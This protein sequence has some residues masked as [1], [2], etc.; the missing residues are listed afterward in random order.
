MIVVFSILPPLL[1][2]LGVLVVPPPPSFH[3]SPPGGISFTHTYVPVHTV[4]SWHWG[5]R[6]GGGGNLKKRAADVVSG[7]I[8]CF[9]AIFKREPLIFFRAIEQ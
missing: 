5:Y 6:G 4:C 1:H 7:A 2:K 9:S 3:P 8:K